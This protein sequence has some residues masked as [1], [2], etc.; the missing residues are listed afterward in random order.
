MS[1]ST[2]DSPFLPAASAPIPGDTLVDGGIVNNV[3]ADGSATVA[4]LFNQVFTTY[5]SVNLTPNVPA[6]LAEILTSIAIDIVVG[7]G[8]GFSIQVTGGQTGSTITVGWSA[9][10]V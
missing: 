5:A 4:V 7:A 1:I 3:P 9:V 6:A 2:Q 10:G 8:G